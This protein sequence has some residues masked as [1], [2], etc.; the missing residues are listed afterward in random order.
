VV[1][2]AIISV[3]LLAKLPVSRFRPDWSKP[4]VEED[5]VLQVS[6][7]KSP[8]VHSLAL[9]VLCVV[10]GAAH[11]TQL[12]TQARDIRGIESLLLLISWVSLQVCHVFW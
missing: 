2:L 3:L 1:P 8:P 6:S 4:F 10:A 9:L 7:Q 5:P 12:I 11:T